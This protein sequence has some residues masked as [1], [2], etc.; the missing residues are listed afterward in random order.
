MVDT[1]H[2]HVNLLGYFSSAAAR[3]EHICGVHVSAGFML[4]LSSRCLMK[5][6]YS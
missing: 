3:S 1:V 6:R 4:D 5:L 2:V